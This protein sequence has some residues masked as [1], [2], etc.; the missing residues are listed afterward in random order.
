MLVYDVTNPKSFRQL[1]TW[2]NEFLKNASPQ[3]PESFPFVVLGNKVDV[4]V[5]RRAVDVDKAQ[6][7]CE[8]QVG[9][10]PHFLVR[11][12]LPPSAQHWLI[13]HAREGGY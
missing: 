3:D 1:A 7:W 13:V 12:S 2:R 4:P 10:I 6:R 5:D 8:E 11:R 9:P